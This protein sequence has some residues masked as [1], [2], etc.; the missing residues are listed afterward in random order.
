M[1]SDSVYRVMF[2]ILTILWGGTVVWTVVLFA[3]MFASPIPPDGTMSVII[4]YVGTCTGVIAIISI[5]YTIIFIIVEI[6]DYIDSW[7]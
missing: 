2:T 1:I 5:I 6:I 7:C 4:H 3:F